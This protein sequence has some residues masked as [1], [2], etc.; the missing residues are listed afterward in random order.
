MAFTFLHTADL[1]LGKSFRELPPERAGQRRDDLLATLKRLCREARERRVSL[2]C[3][4][5]DLFDRPA[6]AAPLLAAVRQALAEASVP[7]LLIPGN[8]DSL[9]TDSPYLAGGWPGNVRVANQ[10]G[11]QQ[12]EI[13]GQ[14]VWAFGYTRGA[15]HRNPW[16]DFPGCSAEAL[17]VLHAACLGAGLAADASYFPFTPSDIPPCAYLALGHHH[18]QVQMSNAP[19]AWYP[20]SPEPLEPEVTPA[21]ALLVTLDGATAGVD[22]LNI[23]TRRHRLVT[24]KVAGLTGNEIWDRALAEAAADDLLYLKLT[25]MLDATAALDLNALQADLS[26]RSFA[27]ELDTTQLHLPIEAGEAEGVMGALQAI[28]GQRL[29]ALSADDPQR[30]RLERAVRYAALA[31]DGRL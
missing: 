25:G 19:Q 31:L 13:D 17:L 14:E 27:V 6:P 23:A 7:V 9:E 8:H 11:W 21:T 1:H 18:R 16:A 10:P 2:L 29:A 26:A 3:L 12:L 22:R 15:A 4:A 20:G 24:L 5:G 28:A 30:A